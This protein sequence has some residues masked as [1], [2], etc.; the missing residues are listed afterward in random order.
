MDALWED[1]EQKAKKPGIKSVNESSGQRELYGNTDIA[2]VQQD[3]GRIEQ[4]EDKRRTAKTL[5]RSGG[6]VWGNTDFLC[7]ETAGNFSE[8]PCR[9]IRKAG[10][11]QNSLY[12]RNQ[13]GMLFS[14][15]EE[16]F[17]SFRAKNSDA[18]T[19]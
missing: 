17:F 11:K 2:K 14:R 1:T 9:E 10:R 6:Y 16:V 7:E 12:L 13:V 4:V 15:N 18:N 3:R 5:L 8:F 19:D